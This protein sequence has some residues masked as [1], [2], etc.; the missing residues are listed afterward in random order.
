MLRTSPTEHTVTSLPKVLASF[1]FLVVAVTAL[2]SAFAHPGYASGVCANGTAECGKSE[3]C[4]I[5][6][7][8]PPKTTCTTMY[9]YYPDED[10]EIR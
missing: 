7:I 3:S 8:F 6:S 10:H 5:S 9:T 2:V 4:V 1:A